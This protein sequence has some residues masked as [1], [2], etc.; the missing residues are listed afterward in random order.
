MAWCPKCKSEYVSGIA[1]CADC[2]CELVDELSA[3]AEQQEAEIV[4]AFEKVELPEEITAQQAEAMMQ[5]LM[6]SGVENPERL[7]E[8]LEDEMAEEWQAASSHQS[9]YVNNEEKAQEH[10]ASAFSL[11]LVGGAGLIFVLL[12]FFGMIPIS[13]TPTGRYMITGI[14]SA[15]FILFIILGMSALRNSEVLKRK[16]YKENNLTREIKKWCIENMVREE[17]D[18]RL[19]IEEQAEELKYF[20]RCESV[21]QSIKNQFLNLD[22]AYLDR[23]VD[24]LYPELFEEDV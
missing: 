3:E 11:I 21:R 23:L 8:L 24:E 16:A 9:P 10:R 12:F 7:E 18:A 2:G 13:V 17:I 14:L 15:L 22:D 4:E 6:E 19:G 1:V 5:V 20:Q